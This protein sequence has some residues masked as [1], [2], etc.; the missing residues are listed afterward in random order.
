VFKHD[1]FN[2]EELED[3]VLRSF[4]RETEAVRA[5]R[6]GRTPELAKRW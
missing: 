3:L 1:Y 6:N 5:W 2:N 4:P